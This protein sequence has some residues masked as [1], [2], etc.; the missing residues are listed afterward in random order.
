MSNFTNDPALL[1]ALEQF[2]RLRADPE[3]MERYRQR[4]MYKLE[5][6]AIK[7]SIAQAKAETI[8]RVLDG[9]YDEVPQE[10]KNELLAIEDFGEL[11]RLLAMAFIC[12]SL[13]VFVT[14]LP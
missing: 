3:L 4:H 10:V 13:N 2:D 6:N 7:A 14:H 12:P 11:D 9:I 1:E 8:I 5:L